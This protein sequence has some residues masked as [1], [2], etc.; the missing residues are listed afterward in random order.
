[1]FLSCV[2]SGPGVIG[3]IS[4]ACGVG[5]GL[6]WHRHQQLL[7][8]LGP[9]TWVHT[10]AQSQCASSSVVADM[11]PGSWVGHL[12]FHWTL[13]TLLWNKYN[14]PYTNLRW[15]DRC[16]SSRLSEYQN[17]YLIWSDNQVVLP[18]H[19]SLLYN[20][21]DSYKEI[22]VC[23]PFIRAAEK[24][25]TIES[26]SNAVRQISKLTKSKGVTGL[27]HDMDIL[28][29]FQAGIQNHHFDL[30]FLEHVTQKQLVL[31]CI[32]LSIC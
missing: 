31:F 27:Y 4:W 16:R 2:S 6:Q 22:L 9:F 24:G 8:D 11:L 21:I 25:L 19:Q 29:G 30:Y 20:I 13:N 17:G 14:I 23:Q 5:K 26:F 3:E 32:S 1:M 12:G 18:E 7:E 10:I 28:K 15:Q